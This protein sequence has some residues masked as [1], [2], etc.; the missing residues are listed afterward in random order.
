MPTQ[1]ELLDEYGK[2]L[3][4]NGELPGRMAVPHIWT[5]EAIWQQGYNTYL[6]EQFDEAM[7]NSRQNALAMRRDEHLQAIIRERVR[8]VVTRKW[9]LETDNDNDPANQQLV[10][11][12]TAALKKTPHLQQFM[13]WLLAN[14][15][16]TGRSG[17][18]VRYEWAPISGFKCLTI[19]EHY[20]INGDKIGFTHDHCP[21]VFINAGKVHTLKN[22]DIA[23]TNKNFAVVLRGSWRERVIIHK[24]DV[25][26]EDFHEAE[27]VDAVHGFGIRN[28]L[29][30][31][32]W[33]KTKFI[34]SVIRALDK[35]GLG[36]VLVRYEEGS[37]AAKKAAMDTAKNLS[38]DR[39]VF[40]VPVSAD[41]LK[42]GGMVEVVETPVA[43]AQVMLE[44]QQAAEA[45][46]ERFI[47]GQTASSR[48][49]TGGLGTHDTDAMRETK[50]QILEEDA[51]LLAET[52]TGSVWE[53]GLVSMIQRWSF[54]ELMD[55]PVRWV[56][57]LRP[58]NVGETISAVSSLFQTGITFKEKEVRALAGLSDPQPGDVV[59]SQ[60]QLQQ[61]QA[62]QMAQQQGQMGGSISPAGE[63]APYRGPEGGEGRKNVV[64]GETEYGET[65]FREN[66]AAPGFERLAAAKRYGAG[67]VPQLPG[68]PEPEGQA[69]HSHIH[70]PE[71]KNWFG[72]WD[73]EPQNASKVVHDAPG[74]AHHGHPKETYPVEQSKV[75]DKEGKPIVV[76]HGT[77]R[78]GFG[79]YDKTKQDPN[80]L[81]G[82]GFY[83]TEDKGVAS[84]YQNKDVEN[85]KWRPG[86]DVEAADKRWREVLQKDQRLNDYQRSGMF[87]FLNAFGPEQLSF[88]QVGSMSQYPEMHEFYLP[89]QTNPETKAVYLNIRKPFDA[90]LGGGW[91]AWANKGYARL[92]YDKLADV[93]GGKAQANE[94]LKKQGYD[95]ITH[96]G[97]GG[98]P[99]SPHHRVW[100]AFE[101]NQIKSTQNRGTFD[102]RNEHIDY[103]QLSAPTA[104]VG[105]PL[106]SGPEEKTHPSTEVH[107]VPAPEK[108]TEAHP[109][110]QRHERKQ[111][112]MSQPVNKLEPTGFE[113]GINQSYFAHLNQ[114]H[115][116]VWKPQSG[117]MRGISVKRGI[118]EGRAYK[119]E[120]AASDVADI[121]GFNDLVPVTGVRKVGNDAGSI[122]HRIIDSKAGRDVSSERRYDAETDRTRAA[123]YDYLIGM[124]DRHAGN[125][126][127]RSD[128]KLQLIDHGYAFPQKHEASDYSWEGF[129]QPETLAKPVPKDV[130]APMMNKWPQVEKALVAQGLEPDAVS[131]ARE[132]YTSLMDYGRMGRAIGELPLHRHGANPLKLSDLD[133]KA[134]KAAGAPSDD[135]W[136]AG[137]SLSLPGQSAK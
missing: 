137:E 120:A 125:W 41:G 17:N 18:Q 26:D 77:A 1:L 131:A 65:P 113:S 133:F 134:S 12:L 5:F 15:L 110:M 121:L 48:S 85:W 27:R 91:A 25:S 21:Y 66:E 97:G 126:R 87:S 81:Y 94:Y 75:V 67:G 4:R 38:I 32:W 118:P 2:P 78:G 11:V 100:I 70:A 136:F 10:K 64:T 117:E 69:P 86:A 34:T 28:W 60:L 79:V 40:T 42:S 92:G 128:G 88:L 101:P 99:E 83:H 37:D 49:E 72:H 108:V 96:I 132:R 9:H 106:V 76:Y 14:A 61:Q 36:F 7:R 57:D 119:S 52:M 123:L 47:I 50:F 89:P 46:E 8:Q 115:H 68:Q 53:P 80:A 51:E 22:A 33:L 104:N 135:S 107:K 111:H 130:V 102:P 16:W 103:G 116:G 127:V 58:P 31:S 105:Q 109:L 74:Q 112:L 114:G 82:P 39:S 95:G 35:L 90:G 56:F 29:Y 30:W 20:P 23:V 45:R 73:R 24:V 3:R 55:V 98:T 19:A 129:W 63:W 124:T 59:I 84:S 6:H 44:L 54:P 93:M 43:G 62:Q 122:Q 71:F 13:T